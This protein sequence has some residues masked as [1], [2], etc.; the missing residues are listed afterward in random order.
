MKKNLQPSNAWKLCGVVFPIVG[1]LGFGS[2]ILIG[3][4]AVASAS[5]MMNVH[6]AETSALASASAP[7]AQTNSPAVQSDIKRRYDGGV[8]NKM[9]AIQEVLMLENRKS[10]DLYGKVV[11]QYVKLY[12]S[13][14]SNNNSGSNSAK[15]AVDGLMEFAALNC[16]PDRIKGE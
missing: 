7:L 12:R 2:R 5:P 13:Y 16:N 10:L 15:A 6:S 8:I 4:I 3:L 1:N 14:Y 9:E 11:D